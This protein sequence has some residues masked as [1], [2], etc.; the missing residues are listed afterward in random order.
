MRPAAVGAGVDGQAHL[1]VAHR[2]AVVHAVQRPA[3]A[4]DRAQ[5]EHH[6]TGEGHPDHQRDGVQRREQ[7]RYHKRHHVVEVRAQLDSPG[8]A[9][10]PHAEQAAPCPGLAAG[11]PAVGA[12]L[13]EPVAGGA[14]RDR[15][16]MFEYVLDDEPP[17]IVH[18]DQAGRLALVE[19]FDGVQAW[20]AARAG[21]FAVGRNNHVPEIAQSDAQPGDPCH[22]GPDQQRDPGEH[23]IQH[24]QRHAHRQPDK[25]RDQPK[26]EFIPFQGGETSFGHRRCPYRSNSPLRNPR[27][28]WLS[29]KMSGSSPTQGRSRAAASNS[30]P[31]R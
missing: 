26:D 14:A 22:P 4:V 28:F 17:G 11:F 12:R 10:Q 21:G 7:H 5:H 29:G 27:D 18:I 24:Q 6:H 3:Q 23:E 20:G 16:D 8:G 13:L 1:R 15:A 25:G 2:A 19:A 30:R 9:E 31:T